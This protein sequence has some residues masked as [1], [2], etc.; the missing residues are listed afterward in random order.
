MPLTLVIGG[1]RSGKSTFAERLAARHDRVLYVATAFVDPNDAEMQA[2][3]AHHRAS[4]DAAWPTIETGSGEPTL[5]RVLRDAEAGTALLVDSLGS[6]LGAAMYAREAQIEHDTPSAEA[7]LDDDAAR[8]R[9]ALAACRAPVVLV[10]EEVG[11]GVVPPSKQGR[12]FRDVMGRA[13]QRLAALAD[14]VY[15]V[16]AG[17]PLDLKALGAFTALPE[18]E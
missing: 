10:S 18:H 16:V 11:Y 4:R 9:E 7:A 17:I 15:L 12:V 13:N 3:V 8:L 6:W 1:V 14:E 5:E 2:R